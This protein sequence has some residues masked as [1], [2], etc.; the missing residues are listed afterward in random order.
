[1]LY[2]YPVFKQEEPETYK[3]MYWYFSQQAQ[4][5]VLSH[6]LAGTSTHW[7]AYYQ[8]IQT[9]NKETKIHEKIS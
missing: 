4:H 7:V 3:P 2:E 6:E 5:W 9:Y 8:N 1:M